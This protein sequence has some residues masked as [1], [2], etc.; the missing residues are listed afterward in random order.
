M[1]KGCKECGYLGYS[2]RIGIYVIMPI[3]REIKRLIAQGAHD[4]EIEEAAVAAGMVTLK[5]SCLKHI[6][7]HKEICYRKHYVI[8]S[9]II[10]VFYILSHICHQFHMMNRFCVIKHNSTLVIVCSFTRTHIEYLLIT[11]KIDSFCCFIDSL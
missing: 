3:T 6:V 4:I 9:G 10:S 2:G 5:T 11:Q 8:V 1:K 7:E